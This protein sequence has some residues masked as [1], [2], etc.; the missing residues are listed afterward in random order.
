LLQHPPISLTAFAPWHELFPSAPDLA[1][2]GR[3]SSAFSLD[4]PVRSLRFIPGELP[5]G[6]FGLTINGTRVPVDLLGGP[7]NIPSSALKEG[8]N[9]LVVTVATTLNM[10]MRVVSPDVYG[11]REREP[12]GVSARFFLPFFAPTPR[13]DVRSFADAITSH[14]LHCAVDQCRQVR[15]PI[16]A[17]FAPGL[18]VP[19]IWLSTFAELDGL[20]RPET[21]RRAFFEYGDIC[22]SCGQAGSALESP[23]QPSRGPRGECKFELLS[24][25]RCYSD[26]R[27]RR[28]NS[29][30][31]IALHTSLDTFLILY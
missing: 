22:Q 27:Q 17:P 6:T 29:A 19:R 8:E 3:Y 31:Q 21:S 9:E 25:R 18:P 1:G 7:S 13:A 23:C 30:I 14:A 5:H 4:S 2:L 28:E 20:D 16:C 26:V 15:F 12:Y 24:F 10:K 11:Q